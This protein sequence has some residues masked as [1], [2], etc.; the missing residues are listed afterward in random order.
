YLYFLER[1]RSQAFRNNQGDFEAEDL[2]TP[3]R[4][5][6]HLHQLISEH[7]NRAY[8]VPTPFISTF[9]DYNHALIW[10]RQRRPWAVI[11]SIDTEKLDNRY[12]WVFH[13]SE[14]TPGCSD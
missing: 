10:A 6:N 14:F 4:G 9:A 2:S 1:S 13:A 12:C 11:Y 5:P 7:V 3:L 8:G